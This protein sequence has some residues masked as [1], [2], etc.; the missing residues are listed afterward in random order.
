MRKLFII[1]L[2]GLS[3]C[4]PRCNPDFKAKQTG[5][6]RACKSCIYVRSEGMDL[7]VDTAVNPNKIYRITFCAGFT[8]PAYIVDYLTKIN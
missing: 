6:A 2:I 7:A 5:L 8:Y 3:S 1:A 4:T